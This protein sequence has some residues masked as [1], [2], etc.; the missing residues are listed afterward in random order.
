M[1]FSAYTFH[2]LFE[3][4][5]LFSWT[6]AAAAAGR[7]RLFRAFKNVLKVEPYFMFLKANI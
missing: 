4:L 1:S 5:F 3:F 2:T 6:L 7:W